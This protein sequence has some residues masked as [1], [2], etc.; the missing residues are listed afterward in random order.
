MDPPSRVD[1]DVVDTHEVVAGRYRLDRSL[2]TSRMSEVFAATDL[3]LR[4][5]VAVKRLPSSAMQDA[6]AKARFA[7]EARALARVNHPNVVTVFDI[8]VDDGRPFLIMELVDGVT[9]RHLVDA[10]GRLDPARVA[11]IAAEICSGL[12]AVHACEIVHRDM[13]PSNVFLTTSGSV[14]IGDFGIASVAS[15]VTLTRAGEVFGS[16]PYVSPEQVTGDPVDARADLYAL[17]CVMFEMATGRPPFVG[18]DPATL[19]YQHVHAAPERADALVP[20]VPVTLASTIDRLMAKDPA[21]RPTSA[22]E[23]R[24]SLEAMP[25][26]TASDVGDAPTQPLEPPVATD[27]LPVIPPPM[28]PRRTPRSPSLLPW[29]AGLVIGI[30]LLLILNAIYGGAEPAVQARTPAAQRSPSSASS[31]SSTPSSPSPTPTPTAAAG[32]VGDAA[33]ALI[34]LVEG[35]GSSGAVGDDLARDLQDGVDQIVGALDEGDGGKML[36]ELGRLQDKVDKG[37]DHGEI[38]ADSAQRL[39]EAIQGL[40]SAVDANHEEGDEGDEGD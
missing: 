30:V 38:S 4:R 28:P 31:P 23:L 1:R 13:K 39:E 18:D 9:L 26:S 35:L 15:D 8:V 7:R 20:Q 32:S 27:V 19:G 40:A 17:G 21:D 6:T 14:K 37:L 10:E 36:D 12:A 16:A 11:S 2:G 33:A 34:G 3:Q 22:D 29:V 5:S 25:L 24:R